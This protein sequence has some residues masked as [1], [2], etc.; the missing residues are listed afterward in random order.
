MR[1]EEARS[2]EAQSRVVRTRRVAERSS[3][4]WSRRSRTSFGHIRWRE[5]GGPRDKYMDRSA[6]LSEAVFDSHVHAGTGKS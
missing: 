5:R 4:F 6:E 3:Q 1:E 2:R